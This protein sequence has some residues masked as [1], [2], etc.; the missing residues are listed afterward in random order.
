MNELTS[1]EDA[2]AQVLGAIPAP[3]AAEDVDLSD[4]LGRVLAATLT[5]PSAL[6]SF[7]RS[8]M[9]GY[10]VRSSDTFGA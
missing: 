10:A 7:P 9:D 6:P 1:I 2:R 8:T 5:A 3:L 4:A